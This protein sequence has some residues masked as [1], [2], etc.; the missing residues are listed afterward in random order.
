MPAETIRLDFEALGTTCH[1]FA[2]GVAEGRLEQA[3]DYVREMHGRLTRFDQRSELSR[4]NAGAGAG[5]QPVSADLEELL[6]ESLRAHRLSSG[7]VNPAVL[8]SMLAIGYT[9]PLR[10]GPTPPTL[11]AAVPLRPLPEVLEVERGRARLAAGAGVDL[12]GIAKGWLADQIA[13]RLLGPDS[14]VNL[15]GDLYAA[16]PGPQGDGWPVGIGP[17]SV[18]LCN[19]GAATSATSRRRWQRPEGEADLHHLIDPRTGA[20]AE[21]DL[22]IVSVI[23][24]RA[25]DAE[26]VAKTALLLGSAQAPAY[27]AANSLGWWM[28]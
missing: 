27:L 3:A 15:G 14:L 1:L 16:G 18:L 19:Q 6:R 26:V 8:A 13:G 23:A 12:G 21:S 7:L 5:W 17:A 11:A 20:P 24:A 2:R 25:T 10:E 9:R 28:D 4:F 22:H